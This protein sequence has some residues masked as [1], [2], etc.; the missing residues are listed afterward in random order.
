MKL[1]F[2]LLLLSAIVFFSCK[3]IR[4]LKQLPPAS[5]ETSGLLTQ[6]LQQHP[7]WFE[8]FI[9]DKDRYKIQIIY[10]Q[11][12]RRANNKPVFTDYYFNVNATNY[13]YPASTVK[14]PVA[15]FALEEI[16]KLK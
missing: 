3:T 13:F 5:P 7:D 16:K 4:T 6:L 14:M 9:K 11:I 15:L 12:D 8:P 1:R 2:I 10:T